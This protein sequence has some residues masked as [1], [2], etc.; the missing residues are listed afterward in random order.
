ME[1][2]REELLKGSILKLF[3]KYFIPTLIGSAAVVLYNIV[4]RFF[5]GKISEKAL[6]GA[7]IAFY[8]VMLII[9]FSMFIGVGAGTIISIRLGQGKKGEAKKILGNAVTLFTILGLS[10]YVLLI[11]NI[12]TVLRYS[13]ANNETLPYAK[14]YLE[15][16]LLAILPLFY[17]FG[18]TNVL[19]AAGAPRVAMFS[20]L[21]GAIV[22]I[23]LDYV[24][25]MIM[26][27]GIEGTAYATLIGNVL[28]A[29]FVLWFLTAGK[30]PFRID[31]FGFKLEEESV[32]TIRF[33]KMKLDSKIVKD[34]FSIGM[35]P[36]LLQAASS[37]VG[38]IT[39][40]IVDTYGG[41]YGVAVM[42]IINSYLPIMTMSVYA[43]SQA[44]QP[45]I[46]FNYG[47]RNFRRVKK[48]LMTAINA[49]VAL[50]FTFWIIVML[51]PKEL[52]LFFNEKSTPEALREGVKAIRV[53]FSLVI[54]SS[55]GITVPNYFQAT[56]RS[57]YSV[58]LN[59]LRQVV[60]FLIVMITFSNIWKLDGVWLAQPFTDLLFFI[61]LL[62]FLYKE[63][64]FFDKMIESENN[65]LEYNKEIDEQK[66]KKDKFIR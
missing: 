54:I 33:S 3:V 62:G 38:L 2:K 53:Y 9:A 37:G 8:I 27:T 12:N 21:I 52:I 51:L 24:A 23:A 20:M 22:N 17:S 50:S 16:I 45:I 64:R 36:F 28:S 56:G 1:K 30:L 4:D 61:I 49:G 32:I 46:G 18:L 25:V 14:A 65:L 7:G 26:H 6:A 57:K 34:I 58:I 10:L 47:A 44:V 13:G 11:L 40:K 63:K 42:T 31:M 5:V 43:V 59:L 48:S 55:F 19:N 60:I 29:I 41:T 35:S 15:I 66:N 39:N